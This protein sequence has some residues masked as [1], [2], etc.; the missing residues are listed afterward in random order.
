M[1]PWKES[2]LGAKKIKP[3]KKLQKKAVL[4]PDTAFERAKKWIAKNSA[5]AFGVSAAILLVVAA[6]WGYSAYAHSKQVRARSGYG[7][8]LARL[9]VEGK[10]TSADW[11]KLLPDLQKFISGNSDTAPALDARV[12]LAKAYFEVQ[13][14]EDAIKTGR[15]ALGLAPQ[16]YGLRPLILYQLGYA[17][18]AAGK[19]DEA[20]NQWT[21]LKQLGVRDLEREADW[22]LGRIAEMRKDSAKALEMYQLASR[23]PGDYPSVSMVDQKIVGMKTVSP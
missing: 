8:L 4:P 19:L 13:R 14:Y 23:A 11:E 22:N 2:A 15:E 9:P 21:G 5:I 10:G 12:E 20:A 17:C 16:G 6:V 7:A 18:E 1:N 3:V